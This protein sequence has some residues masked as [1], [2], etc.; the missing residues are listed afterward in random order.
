MSYGPDTEDGT[1]GGPWPAFTDLLAATTLLFLVLFTVGALPAIKTA[2]ERGAAAL[3]IKELSAALVPKDSAGKF[4]V[5]TFPDYLLIRIKGDATFPKG[6]SG[7]DSLREEGKAI[8]R[9]LASSLIRDSLLRHV[10]VIQVA[11]HTSSEGSDERNWLL[12]AQRASSVA[13]YLIEKGRLDPCKVTALGRGRYYPV[14]TRLPR[15]A[16]GRPEDRRIEIEIRPVATS[17]KTQ[18]VAPQCIR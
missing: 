16:E 5:I 11:G 7:I 17:Q 1:D 13:L 2:R 15:I 6:A 10:E 12:S 8:L 14:N 18:T 3:E 9:Q 4:T